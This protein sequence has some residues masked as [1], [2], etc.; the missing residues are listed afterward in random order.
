[1][2]A[3]HVCACSHVC[4]HA[5]FAPTVKVLQLAWLTKISDLLELRRGL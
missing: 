4:P 2:H 5:R 3:G 1:M